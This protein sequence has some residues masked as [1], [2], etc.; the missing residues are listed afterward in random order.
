[1]EQALLSR[2]LSWRLGVYKSEFLEEGEELQARTASRADW[3]AYRGHWKDQ[4]REL[5]RKA[6]Y[7]CAE[8]RAELESVGIFVGRAAPGETDDQRRR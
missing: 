1:M 8:S 4:L 2:I 7:G 6:F 5:K 3:A